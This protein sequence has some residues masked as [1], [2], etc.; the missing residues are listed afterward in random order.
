LPGLLPHYR[1]GKVRLLGISADQRIAELPEVPTYAEL[2]FP[3][4]S[5]VSWIGTFVHKATPADV[6]AD[7]HRLVAAALHTPAFKA[8]MGPD[9][10]LYALQPQEFRR[11][12]ERD[13]EKW[14]ALIRRL[15]L[16]TRLG[17]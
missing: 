1:A 2:G 14:G 3:Q 6:L 7:V 16:V 5:Y 4:S 10:S 12:I 15:N 17:A 9:M 11:L 8:Q 13:V